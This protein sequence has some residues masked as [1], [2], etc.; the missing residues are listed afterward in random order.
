ML[1]NKKIITGLDHKQYEH[2][3]D[4]M[5]LETL[6]KTPGLSAVGKYISKQTIER[7]YT[8]QYTGSNLRIISENYPHIYDYLDYACKILDFDSKPELYVQWGFGINAC[9]IGSERP[10][11]I[12]NSGLIDLCNDDEKL[13]IIG[14]ELG[15]IKSNHMLY[16]MMAQLINFIIDSIPGGNIIGGPLRYALLYWDRMSEFTA[17]RAGLLCC[18]NINAATSAFVKMAGLPQSQYQT[19]NTESFIQQAKDFTNLDYENMN[20]FF[21]FVSI[22]D[23]TH[24]WTVLRA[25]ELLK[26]ADEGGVS[27]I[28]PSLLQPYQSLSGGRKIG[29]TKYLLP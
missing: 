13:F 4:R 25:S 29:P 28:H 22:I 15:H 1:H 18:Q 11:I 23:S 24:P 12:I 17:D 6:E 10:I 8:V 9:T 27:S 7:I 5:A 2:P 19:I 20:K 3:F 21:K 14:H 16:H 26:W